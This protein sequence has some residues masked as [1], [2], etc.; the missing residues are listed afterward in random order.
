[1]LWGRLY[2]LRGFILV[3]LAI[4]WLAGIFLSSLLNMPLVV[5][6]GGIGIAF[7]GI[8]V[9]LHNPQIRMLFLLILCLLIGA[10]R[11]TSTLPDNDPQA[12]SRFI[13]A[14]SVSVKGTVEDEPKL[15]GRS[16][17]FI[18]EANTISQS[19]TIPAIAVH[20]KIE[21]KTLGTGIE[22]SYGANYG[23]SVELQGKLQTA[24][25]YS[26][27]GVFASMVFPRLTVTGS[28]GLP[29]IGFLYH[30][31]NRCAVIIEQVLPQPSAA[32]LI[33]ILLGLR[34]PGLT[35]LKLAFNV[36][37]TAHLIVP[38]GFKVTILAGLVVSGTRWLY[39][40]HIPGQAVASKHWQNWI[41][42]TLIIGSIGAYTVLSGAGPA[43]IRA[44]VMGC[45]LILAPRIGRNYNIYTALALSSIVMSGIDPFILWDTGFLLSFLG[46]LGIVLLAPYFQSL[47]HIFKALPC[48]QLASEMI[49]VTLAAQL[50]TL[51]I[52]ATTFQQV[53]FIAPIANLLTVP[54][55]SIL[56]ASGMLICSIGFVSLPI[57]Q[58]C[59]WVAWP[60][61]T[62]M[63]NCILW[64]ASIPGAYITVDN[65]NA[66]LAWIY[67][68]LFAAVTSVI[69]YRH[70]TVPKESQKQQH[71][72]GNGRKI[73]RI[74]QWSM[75]CLFIVA[76]GIAALTPQTTHSLSIT[77][78]DVGPTNEPAQ[79]EAIFIR[80]ADNKTVLIDGGMDATSLGQALDSRLPYW[81]RSL[82]I[83][84]LTTPRSDHLTGLLDIV[85]RYQIGL[86]CDASMLHPGTTYARWRRT[87]SEHNLHYVPVSTGDTIAVGADVT[88]QVLWPG[89]DL[90]KGSDEARDNGLVIHLVAPGFRILF[91]GAA[92]QS[93]YALT[94]LANGSQLNMLQSE[95]VQIVG[96]KDK[97]LAPELGDIL[98]K[99]R[100]AAVI[101]TP[102][103]LSAAQR[104]T[105]TTGKAVQQPVLAGIAVVKTEQVGSV[106]I[107]SSAT[108]WDMDTS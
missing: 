80:T 12:I 24:T 43:A 27:A 70:N 58:V 105:S 73:W 82:D 97:E 23:D 57:A 4:A 81:Q 91:L 13:S 54:L 85:T 45:L 76:T 106:E 101:I 30:L 16:R 100:P 60:L 69:L 96:E 68:L 55:L 61:L 8:V 71:V 99:A 84:I 92:A 56:V 2:T 77:F 50:A 89:K 28:G 14:T 5:L 39:W 25:P 46:T 51:P 41:A 37:G 33:A 83:V 102:A 22:D 74:V 53:S 87:I 15:Q 21:V 29:I 88:L 66:G 93:R 94:G 90:H 36:T 17:V 9:Y 34:T 26:P 78:F 104:K 40:I 20:G 64:C 72:E 62:Y 65:I 49:A 47:L 95:I 38:S 10:W 1:M 31:R 42:T 75:I 103:S 86:I 19:P 63:S 59:S 6:T 3:G 18:V 108:G 35:P 98:K 44:G 107:I 79:G 32:L 11:Y 67:Y 48:G 7:L 52:F